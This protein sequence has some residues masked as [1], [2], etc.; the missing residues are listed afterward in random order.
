[1]H[2]YSHVLDFP[3]NGGRQSFRLKGVNRKLGRHGPPV[4]TQFAL[5]QVLFTLALLRSAARQTVHRHTNRLAETKQH[6][7]GI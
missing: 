2:Y 6:E 1:M 3:N 7:H 4:A 5:K